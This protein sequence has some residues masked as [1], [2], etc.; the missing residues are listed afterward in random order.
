MKIALEYD[1]ACL[2]RK[3]LDFYLETL[4]KTTPREVIPEVETLLISAASGKH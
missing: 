3:V 4:N 1:W 2:A